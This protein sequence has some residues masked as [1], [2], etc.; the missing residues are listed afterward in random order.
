M[1]RVKRPTIIPRPVASRYQGPAER[2]IEV[3]FP[4]GRGGLVALRTLADGR[5]VIELYRSDPGI[6]VVGPGVPIPLSS[7]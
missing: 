5:D 7:D 4:S 6:I 3:V 1:A 2:I